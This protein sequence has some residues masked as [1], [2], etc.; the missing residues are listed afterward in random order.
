[1]KKT[2]L[3]CACFLFSSIN[4]TYA[5]ESSTYKFVNNLIDAYYEGHLAYDKFNEMGDYKSVGMAMKEA[6]DSKS[7]TIINKEKL[8]I[9]PYISMKE[10]GMTEEK[11]RD[12]TLTMNYHLKKI[13]SILEPYLN[14]PDHWVQI[15]A[16]LSVTLEESIAI[17]EASPDI[18]LKI[19]DKGENAY[20]EL[21]DEQKGIL[22]TYQYFPGFVGFYLDKIPQVLI[23]NFQYGQSGPINFK[24]SKQERQMLIKKID[25][26]FADRIK[27]AE[28]HKNVSNLEM[29]MNPYELNIY[30]Y[31]IS[32]LR[33]ML[34]YDKYED[35][36]CADIKTTLASGC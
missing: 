14:D 9:L 29:S 25:Q 16:R 24:L 19:M 36:G 10:K 15:F 34:T 6:M 3:I 17:N 23:E 33:K 4:I 8:L 12:N 21:S 2:F 28:S 13:K 30:V 20:D 5:Q 35:A 18:I 11:L 26:E 7:Y 32:S 22:R 27:L 31:L 1:M